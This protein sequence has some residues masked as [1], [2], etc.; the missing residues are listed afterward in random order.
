[1]GRGGG[2]VDAARGS[3][4]SRALQE[5]AEVWVCLWLMGEEAATGLRGPEQECGEIETMLKD[6]GLWKRWKGV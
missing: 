2:A 5:E 3:G 6:T 1:M 4:G